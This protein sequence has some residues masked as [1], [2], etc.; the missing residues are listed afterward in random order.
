MAGR[1]DDFDTDPRS[2]PLRAQLQQ[3]VHAT[4]AALSLSTREITDCPLDERNEDGMQRQVVGEIVEAGCEQ[5]DPPLSD[6]LLEQQ[7]RAV[8]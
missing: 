5:N 2:F 6:G 3:L 8:L 7:R 1:I 4:S